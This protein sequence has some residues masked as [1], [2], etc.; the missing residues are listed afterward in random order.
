VENIRVGEEVLIEIVK[1][2]NVNINKKKKLMRG[3]IDDSRQMIVS[4]FILI[5][6]MRVGFVKIRIIFAHKLWFFLI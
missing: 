5:V 6:N 2:I 3:I 1:I 4:T